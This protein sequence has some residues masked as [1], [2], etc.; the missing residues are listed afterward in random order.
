MSHL[1]DVMGRWLP[2]SRL[3]TPQQASWTMMANR[4]RHASTGKPASAPRRVVSFAWSRPS[5]A[6]WE[7]QS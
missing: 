7:M 5:V 1:L 3:L 6:L 2:I 4:T